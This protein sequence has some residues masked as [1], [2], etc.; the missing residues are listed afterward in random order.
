M[1]YVLEL[2]FLDRIIMFLFIVAFDITV[3]GIRAR[4]QWIQIIT[5]SVAIFYDFSDC[6]L[7]NIRVH[8]CVELLVAAK[9]LELGMVC[10]CWGWSSRTGGLNWVNPTGRAI[11]S[12]KQQ[13]GLG[14]SSGLRKLICHLHFIRSS[15]KY[16]SCRE[17]K[18]ILCTPQ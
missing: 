2:C 17:K 12:Q 15:D 14:I 4:T 16:F 13:G 9:L 6:F 10:M 11:G 1:I 8:L 3:L 7:V 18:G 5:A